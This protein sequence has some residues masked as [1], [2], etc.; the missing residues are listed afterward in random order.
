M[1]CA[2]SLGVLHG[3]SR[4]GFPTR[5]RRNRRRC[6]GIE[7]AE[8]PRRTGQG[9]VMAFTVVNAIEP[10]NPTLNARRVLS[11]PIR[12]FHSS[13]IGDSTP[14]PCKARQNLNA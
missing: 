8:I 3:E 13:H 1:S 2:M 5:T 11:H 4:K 14:C 12:G 9:K 6:G 7:D 10:K